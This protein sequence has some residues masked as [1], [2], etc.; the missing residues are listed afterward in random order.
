MGH[1]DVQTTS[2]YLHH[3]SRADEA[4]LLAGAFEVPGVPSSAPSGGGVLLAD[5]AA[6]TE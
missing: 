5:E 3:K 4:D 6:G 2:R 1:A